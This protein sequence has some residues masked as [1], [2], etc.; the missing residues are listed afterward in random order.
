MAIS[1]DESFASL[2]N[3]SNSLPSRRSRSPLI[4]TFKYF[5]RRSKSKSRIGACTKNVPAEPALKA[6][7]KSWDNWHLSWKRRGQTPGMDDYL[8]LEQLENVWYK[9]DFYVGCISV[10]QEATQYT[11]TEAVEVP[12]IAEHTVRAQRQREQPLALRQPSANGVPRDTAT[13]V[14]GVIH[15]A[16]RPVPYV[17]DSSSSRSQAAAPVDRVAVAVPNTNWTYGRG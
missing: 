6:P 14:D 15:P 3:S 16:L 5:N 7:T 4:T 12:L 10:P 9:Q 8:T 2:Y 1:L 17:V 13:M 11:F